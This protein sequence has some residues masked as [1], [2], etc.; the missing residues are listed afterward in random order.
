LTDT[1]EYNLV[2][3]PFGASLSTSR[4]AR[5]NKMETLL[6]PAMLQYGRKHQRGYDHAIDFGNFSK[7]NGVL[8]T[9][10]ATT[11]NR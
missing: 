1:N 2:S 11:M 4:D 9:N 3:N 7:Y 5:K 8:K 6:A 10:L